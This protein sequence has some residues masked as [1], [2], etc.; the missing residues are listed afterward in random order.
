MIEL[1]EVHSRRDMLE[2]IEFPNRLYAKVPQYVPALVIDELSNLSAKKNPAFEYCDMRYFLARR[3]GKTVGRIGGI[4]SHKANE[5]WHEKKIRITRMDFVEDYEV[6]TALVGVIEAWGAEQGLSEIVG[7]IGFCDLDKE[8][9]LVDGFERDSMFITYYN[10]PYYPEFMQ[11]YGFEKEADWTEHIITMQSPEEARMARISDRL[12]SRGGFRV[13]KL[14]SKRQLK[15]WIPEIFRLINSEYS[16]LYGVVPL[17]ER[18][19]KYYTSQF[20][21]LIN[22]RYVSLIA[23]AEGKL[24]AF[25]VLAPSLAEPMKKCRGRLFPTGWFHLLRAIRHPRILDM[26]LVAVRGDY[27]KSGL[28]AVLMNDIYHR[29]K[30]DHILFAETGPELETN[31]NVQ[32]MWGLFQSEMNVRRR[33][34]WKKEIHKA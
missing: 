11:R 17:T 12:L 32:N 31:L 29:A 15:P 18:Q 4:I 34:S 22:L 19:I 27:R 24:A 25:G 30:A 7:P 5:R 1:Y 6:F 9:M 28:P 8:G 21:T 33:R 2:F 16:Q 14:K 23:D 20:L 10:F 3:N 13:V 26:Y